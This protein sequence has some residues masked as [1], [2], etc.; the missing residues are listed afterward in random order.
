MAGKSKEMELAIKI[1]GKI[2]KSFNTAIASVNKTIRGMTKALAVGSAAAAAAV[3]ALT[4]KAV[5]VGK[6]FETSM[7]QVAATLRLDSATEEGAAQLAI[8]EEAARQCGRETAFSATEAAGGL[9][10]LAMA[11]YDAAEAATALPTVLALAGAGNLEMADSARYLT[12]TMGALGLEKTEENFGHLADVM[13]LTASQAK[14]D[15]SQMGEAFT[16]LGG[17]GRALKGGVDEIA[18]ALGALAN[19]DITGSEAGTHLRNIISS[20]QN[21]RN[22][23]AAAMFKELGVNAYDSTGKMRGLNEIFGDLNTAMAGMT[24]EQKNGIIKTL[25]KETDKNAALAL[26]AQCGEGFD[27]LYQSAMN[28]SEGLGAAQEMYGRQQDNLEGDVAKLNSALSD[29][30]ISVYKNLQPALRGSVQFASEVVSAFGE[31]FSTGDLSGGIGA[32]VEMI[33]GRLGELPEGIRQAG[34]AAAALGAANLVGGI[35]DSKVWKDGVKNV[36]EFGSILQSV[37]TI[38][39]GKLAGLKNSF[40]NIIPPGVKGRVGSTFNSIASGIT[41]L[42]SK[43]AIGGKAFWNGFAG[44]SVLGKVVSRVSAFSGKVGGAIG[45]VGGVVLDTGGKLASGLQAMMG[46]ALKAF[47]P[48]ALIGGLLVVLGLLQSR[49]G[50][51]INGMLEQA[52]IQGPQIISSLAAGIASRIPDILSQ[53]AQLVANFL[54]TVGALAP[55]LIMGGAQILIAL[56]DGVAQNAPMLISGAVS[57]V[58]GFISGILQAL[59]LVLLSGMRLLLGI[60]QGIAQ[61][62]PAMAQGAVQAVLGFIQGFISALPMI[63]TIAGQIVVSLIQGLAAGLPALASGAVQII[64]MLARGFISNLP[65]IV[66]TGIQVVAAIAM[67]ILSAIGTLFGMIPGLFGQL[68]DIIKETDWVQVGADIISSIGDGIKSGAAG[69]WNTIKGAVTGGGKDDNAPKAPAPSGQPAFAMPS[70][71]SYTNAGAQGAAAYAAGFQSGAPQISAATQSAV[72]GTT[73]GIGLAMWQQAGA[74]GGTAFTTGIDGTLAGYQFDT[75]NLGI[76]GAAFA[77]LMGGA[78]EAGGTAFTGGLDSSLLGYSFDTSGINLAGVGDTFQ[79]A[80]E[81][82]GETFTAGL[83]NSF[84]GYT[85]DPSSIGLNATGFISELQTAASDGGSAFTSSLD[86][87]M[88]GYSVDTSSIGIDSSSLTAAMTEAGTAGGQA[89]TDALAASLGASNFDLASAA[90]IDTSSISTVMT[91]AGSSGG[92]AFTSAL[93]SS[94]TG[95]SFNPQSIGITAGSMQG[96]LRPVGTAGGQ[97]LTQAL[98]SAISAGTGS[99]V[100]AASRLAHG[101]SSAISSGF[102]KAKSSAKSAMSSIRST[103]SREAHSAASA[104]KKAFENM[105]ITIPKP[106]I[107]VVHVSYSSVGNPPV[108]VPHFSISYH[109]LGGIFNRATL[110]QSLAGGAHVLGESGPEAILPLDTLWEKMRSIMTEILQGNTGMVDSLLE[111]LQGIGRNNS[112]NLEPARAG[113]GGGTIYFSPT[114][115]LY[116]SASREDAEAAGRTTFEEFK[117]FM[118]KYE[119]DNRRKKF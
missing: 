47:M 78:G 69:I 15:V 67:G 75:T 9:N 62:L 111:R 118:E 103:C 12:A 110:L 98:Q 4:L 81:A 87:S 56:V 8:L 10:N 115:N 53:G 55:S 102:S 96:Y 46:I 74:N 20:L 116:G 51:Q 60:T 107:P 32:A 109:A 95:F 23:N 71:S 45:K 52:R 19:W 26:L 119:K 37:P 113:A 97:A 91:T 100:G 82:G 68:G 92:M 34:A 43:I 117:K 79:A 40:L 106:K 94:L 27:D 88:S 59:P 21:P 93:S 66:Q 41:N 58:G 89:F 39:S 25:F 57:A 64:A 86:G 22:K 44:D 50:M 18:A 14:T 72:D 80:G 35:L 6:E 101:V 73:S 77:S 28:A 30:G 65:M 90:N 49:F 38:A 3:G 11:G 42:G 48:A 85:F 17:N 54:N 13:A 16:A 5:D 33:M 63:L 105:K 29:V 114:Y 83:E 36:N 112:V 7:S 1:A 104:V 76:D 108:K 24:D 31:A 84:A 61:N 2:D 99:V 70:T